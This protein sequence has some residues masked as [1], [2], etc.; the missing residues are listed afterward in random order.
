MKETLTL[1]LSRVAELYLLLLAGY[2]YLTKN[3]S[4]RFFLS[5]ASGSLAGFY[6]GF[7]LNFGETSLA[8]QLKAWLTRLELIF[9]GGLLV[10]VFLLSLQPVFLKG[11][12]KLTAIRP[13]VLANLAVFGVGLIFIGFEGFDFSLKLQALSFLKMSSFP[14][15]LGGFTSFFLIVCFLVGIYFFGSNNFESWLKRK[16]EPFLLL[17]VLLY[18][19]VAT[20]SLFRPELFSSLEVIA[21]RMLHDAVHWIIVFL[22]FPDHPYLKDSFWQLLAL[23]FR[24]E[25]GLIFNLLLVFGLGLLVFLRAYYFP[26]PELPEAKSQAERRKKWAEIKKGRLYSTRFIFVSW[27]FLS[28]AAYSAYASEK[29]LY[30]PTPTPLTVDKQGMVSISLAELDDGLL[31]RYSFNYKGKLVGLLAIKKPDGQLAVCLDDCLICPPDGYAQLGKDLF[32]LYCGTPIPIATVGSPGGC[33][34]IPLKFEVKK[35]KI[36]T[37]AEPAFVDWV[38]NNR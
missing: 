30:F 14:Y 33:N 4:R 9:R 8:Y 31:H 17:P 20:R 11:E 10:A 24:K 25:T 29:T 2:L 34:P 22:A 23:V 38:G 37:A 19:A 35:G 1:T 5:L 21:A 27:I 15:F 3:A 13:Q 26:L 36:I 6:L 16:K 12:E 28:L 18:F 32:C 7:W